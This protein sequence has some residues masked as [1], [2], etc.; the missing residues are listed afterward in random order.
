MLYV[1]VKLGCSLHKGG[2]P[3][4]DKGTTI[5]TRLVKRPAAL[6]L[7]FLRPSKPTG[8]RGVLTFSF[9]SLF[10]KS[11]LKTKRNHEGNN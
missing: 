4:E 3:L 10:L 11:K 7:V 5:M 1:P 6:L 2:P 9:D 8:A